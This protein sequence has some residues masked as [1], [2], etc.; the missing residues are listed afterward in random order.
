MFFGTDGEVSRI[1]EVVLSKVQ[2]TLDLW[3][4]KALTLREGVAVVIVLVL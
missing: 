3:E 2:S 1:W 4:M